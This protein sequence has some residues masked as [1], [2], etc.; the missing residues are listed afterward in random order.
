[1]LQLLHGIAAMRKMDEKTATKEMSSNMNL[2]VLLNTLS[3]Q[4]F[5]T[6]VIGIL[7]SQGSDGAGKIIIPVWITSILTFFLTMFLG[8][9]FFKESKL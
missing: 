2:F 9:L 4:I 5:P 6:T 1:M 3:I 8:N 7:A